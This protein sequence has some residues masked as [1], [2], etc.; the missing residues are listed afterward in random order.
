[1]PRAAVERRDGIAVVSRRPQVPTA[2]VTVPRP[3]PR[4][5]RDAGPPLS[6]A[7]LICAV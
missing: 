1:M 7:W 3:A 2:A 6:R 4:R 5:M